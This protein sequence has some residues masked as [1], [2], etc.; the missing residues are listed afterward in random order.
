MRRLLIAWLV[1]LAAI[2]AVP[3]PAAGYALGAAVPW[4]RVRDDVARRA[5]VERRFGSITPE[6]ELKMERL[7]PLQGAY[8]FASADALVA[9]AAAHGKRVRGHTLV[10]HQQ[11]P[12][13]LRSGLWTPAALRAALV[14][15][16]TTVAAHFRGRVDSW[17]VV[18]EPLDDDG[19]FR[20]GDAPWLPVLGPAYIE[21]ALRAARAAD[22][23]AKLF[24]N[25]VAAEHKGP[26]LDALVRLAADLRARGVPLDGI[27]LQN[28]TDTAG[29]PDRAR[30]ID[31]MRRFAALGLEVE[32]T[33]M[34][35]G[36]LRTPG[37]PADRLTRQAD[38]YGEAAAACDEVRACTRLTVWGLSDRDS[39][40][41]AAERALPFDTA[42][43]PKPAWRALAGPAGA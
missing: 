21:T 17:D 40:R 14:D 30:L 2:A 3:S 28:H 36:T 18:N 29:Y 9:Y 5:L 13:W 15:H 7:Q 27:G 38:A 22:P 1:P 35:V 4:D 39:W 32:I 37:S 12:A 11:H 16:V 42:L 31:T 43:R 20:A 23:D 6:N 33:E 19:T 24:I 26:K 10:W 25:E 34:D 41:G 8:A